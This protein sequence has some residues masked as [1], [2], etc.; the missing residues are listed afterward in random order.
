MDKV[1]IYCGKPLTGTGDI[2]E[3]CS[4]CMRSITITHTYEQETSYNMIRVSQSFYSLDVVFEFC[5]VLLENCVSDVEIKTKDD[6]TMT[7]YEVLW[8]TF[9][10]KNKGE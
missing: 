1:C 7:N 4:D 5:K 2:G 6:G 8:Y 3:V 10:V 9:Q